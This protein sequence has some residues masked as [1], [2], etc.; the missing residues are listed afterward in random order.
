[1]PRNF[2]VHSVTRSH[3]LCRRVIAVSTSAH[4]L[5]R[6][7]WA[8]F[9]PHWSRKDINHWL[10]K[11]HH[12]IHFMLLQAS[13]LAICVYMFVCV[14]MFIVISPPQRW[15]ALTS[16]DEGS[17]NHTAEVI[18]PPA[19]EDIFSPWKF[20]LTALCIV[21]AAWFIPCDK[22][23]IIECSLRRQHCE[24]SHSPTFDSIACRKPAS[25]SATT[26]TCRFTLYFEFF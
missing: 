15:W 2:F 1:M 5:R 12:F 3:T 26:K 23:P 6:K 13:L 19:Q 18:I 9:S 16:D 20:C 22:L 8:F 25:F 24:S 7:G 17:Q 14:L 11:A 10:Q 4:M 21:V